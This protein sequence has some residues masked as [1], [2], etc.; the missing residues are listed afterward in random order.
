MLYIGA[1]HAGFYL[2]EELKKELEEWGYQYEDLGNK[3]LDA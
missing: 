2:K 1:D 3:E